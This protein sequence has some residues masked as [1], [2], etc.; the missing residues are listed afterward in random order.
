MGR[1]LGQTGTATHL[2]RP[3]RSPIR[4]GSSLRRSCHRPQDG[5]GWPSSGCLRRIPFCIRRPAV[6]HSGGRSPIQQAHYRPQFASAISSTH[7]TAATWRSRR[8][9]PQPVLHALQSHKQAAGYLS[10]VLLFLALG[11]LTV[12]RERPLPPGEGSPSARA[13]A[14][15]PA[16]GVVPRVSDCKRFVLQSTRGWGSADSSSGLTGAANGIRS[17]TGHST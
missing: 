14:G 10:P 8:T 16:G 6:R 3:R 12:E 13:A 11:D 4:H 7:Q 17:Q 2:A 1:W 5:N 9:R 15:P